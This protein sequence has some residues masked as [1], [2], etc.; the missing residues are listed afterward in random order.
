MQTCKTCRF[1]SDGCCEL[2]NLTI[3]GES[4]GDKQNPEFNIVVTVAD[5][6]N[7]NVNLRT[8]PDFGCIHHA[9]KDDDSFDDFR[10]QG[11][12]FGQ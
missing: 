11:G 2:V 8:G 10:K 4:Q 9:T 1:W 7:L 3:D 6:W 5:D 12:E